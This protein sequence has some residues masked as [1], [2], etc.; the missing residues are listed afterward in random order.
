MKEILGGEHRWL[1]RELRTREDA[2]EVQEP[3]EGKGVSGHNCPNTHDTDGD[4]F[5]HSAFHDK[6]GSEQ[7]SNHA[8]ITQ[9][10]NGGA[11]I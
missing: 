2:T 10:M 8:L 1:T 4:Q 9:Q 3:N 7:L 5:C 11:R 6:G